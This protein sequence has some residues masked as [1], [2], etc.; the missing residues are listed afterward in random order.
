MLPA[1]SKCLRVVQMVVKTEK[2]LSNRD[3]TGHFSYCST[4]ILKLVLV[5]LSVK[6]GLGWGRG[7]TESSSRT[8]EAGDAGSYE[9]PEG[10]AGQQHTHHHRSHHPCRRQSILKEFLLLSPCA[11]LCMLQSGGKVAVNERAGS[12]WRFIEHPIA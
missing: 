5:W 2:R 10:H 12:Q 8:H 7:I 11:S 6:T 1:S 3:C 4:A 9:A